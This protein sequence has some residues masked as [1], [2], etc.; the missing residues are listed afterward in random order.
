MVPLA[1]SKSPLLTSVDKN[2]QYVV[3]VLPQQGQ[4]RALHAAR[5]KGIAE[6]NSPNATQMMALIEGP[7]QQK[8][9]FAS[10]L[11][12]GKSAQMG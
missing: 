1:T 8:T 4:S 9:G 6:A 10:E 3:N 7:Q 12:A 5:T 11:A 2:D